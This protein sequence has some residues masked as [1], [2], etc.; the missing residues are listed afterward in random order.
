MSLAAWWGGFPVSGKVQPTV[1]RA[2]LEKLQR[3]VRGTVV[4]HR[5][6]VDALRLEVVEDRRQHVD[7]VIA[8]TVSGRPGR[9]QSGSVE[10][11]AGQPDRVALTASS[12][13]R[14]PRT[15][16]PSVPRA[17]RSALPSVSIRIPLACGREPRQNGP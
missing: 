11:G 1:Q 17:T 10:A 16:V 9:P 13:P 15:A 12:E 8:D 3:A 14:S 5:H 7:L 4:R 6:V 2:L